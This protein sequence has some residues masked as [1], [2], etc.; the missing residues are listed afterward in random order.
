VAELD[1]AGDLAAARAVAR[2]A[3]AGAG[4]GGSQP[5]QADGSETT[6]AIRQAQAQADDARSKFQSAERLVKSATSRANG[7]TSS[8]RRTRPRRGARACATTC[9]SSPHIQ[10]CGPEVRLAEK[11]LGDT[12]LRAARR[13]RHAAVISPGQYIKENTPVLTIVKS[14]PLRLRDI[15]ES[16]IPEVKVGTTLTFTTD[17][18]RTRR[19]GRWCASQ[20]RARR[21]SRSLAAEG[22]GLVT[23]TRRLKPGMFVQVLLTISRAA[24]VTAVP[25]DDPFGGRTHQGLRR[26]T[27]W[28]RAPCGAAGR[29][30]R[31]GGDSRRGEARRAGCDQQPGLPHQRHE[32]AGGELPMRNSRKSAFDARSSRPC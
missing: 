1:S 7:S 32:S 10:G 14:S 21:Q 3:G 11:R 17:A 8:R 22:R 12:T 19:S 2:R 15:P 13:G 27:A 4:A 20:L 9:G 25:K 31:M 16:G 23:E 30:G 29:R 5:D 6:P 28:W 24:Q 18:A 26:A